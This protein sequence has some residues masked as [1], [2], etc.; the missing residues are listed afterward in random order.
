MKLG[1]S[2]LTF[3]FFII[4]IGCNKNDNSFPPELPSMQTFLL[5]TK[6]LENDS[7]VFDSK[8]DNYRN[9]FVAANKIYDWN[10][11]ISANIQIPLNCLFL[12][13]QYEPK[14][15]ADRSWLWQ[16]D[17]G[18]DLDTYQ[19]KMY[20]TFEVDSSILW[21]MFVTEN[22]SESVLL[23]KGNINKFFTQGNW[24]FYKHIFRPI[25]ILKIDWLIEENVLHVNFTNEYEKST[26]TGSMLEIIYSIEDTTRVKFNFYNQS[27]NT[28][29][30]MEINKVLGT[31]KIMDYE[32]FNDSL[33][34]CW[35]S[36]FMNEDCM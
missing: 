27:T 6:G 4:I 34:H 16:Y 36:N 33:W 24:I 25:E 20:G 26:N 8:D 3:I 29:S 13:Y 7:F 18:V 11:L 1:I 15:F 31:G 17:F 12:A 35:D 19:I 32:A 5:E 9:W 23:M 2:I 21:E 22:N 10:F 30:Y 14:L 28:N